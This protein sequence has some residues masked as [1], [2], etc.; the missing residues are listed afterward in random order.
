MPH[1]YLNP[2][3]GNIPVFEKMPSAQCCGCEACASACPISIISMQ[4]DKYG[5]LYPYIN[6]EKC[7]HCMKCVKVCPVL[8]LP[9][10][11]SY[12]ER[13]IYAG[14]AQNEQTVLSSSSGGFFEVLAKNF[15]QRKG[16][17]VTAVVWADDF[18]SVYHICGGI[19]DLE[20]MKRSK[21]IQSR[22]GNI[23]SIIK[24]KLENESE[25][26]FVG[27]PCEV[28]GL[29]HYLKKE[30][31]RLYCVDLICQGPTCAKVMKQYAD[32]M[33]QKY[34]TSIKDVNLRYVGGEVW[35]PQWIRIQ[36][37]DGSQYLKKFYETSLGTAFHLMQRPSCYQCKFCSENW[38]SDLTL[39][40]FHGPDKA[41][42]Y[43][44]PKG[45]SVIF[46]NTEKGIALMDN[47]PREK[48]ILEQVTYDEVSK[49]NPR[50]LG[51]WKQFPGSEKFWTD[52][53]KYGIFAA[54]R[55]Y[56][57]LYKKIEFAL[58][59]K[60]RRALSKLRKKK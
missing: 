9:E 58:P 21:Y 2:T 11:I 6:K 13:K 4:E 30:Y 10:P 33:E 1:D 26:L 49:S 57:P 23:H 48:M 46:V 39:G 44:N 17:F 36:F 28:A 45:T 20:R 43:Y 12:Q 42:N 22:K 18:R 27:C 19:N 35:I 60:L 55:R 34:H 7:I 29:K 32:H 41:R 54:T 25:I 14:Y 24:E 3:S 51:S 38:V 52:Y 15:L 47:V 37:E 5:F 56:F 59:I 53:L 50:I 16:S 8:N 40:D 31:K